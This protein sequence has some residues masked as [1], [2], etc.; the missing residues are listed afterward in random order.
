MNSPWERN[1]LYKHDNNTDVAMFIIES[2]EEDDGWNV[3]V[4][5]F[6]VNPKHNLRSLN[7]RDTVKVKKCDIEK[8]RKYT[9]VR[10]NK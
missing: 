1:W 7:I 4:E 9:P 2:F 8:W 6:D 5:W 10:D 3:Y